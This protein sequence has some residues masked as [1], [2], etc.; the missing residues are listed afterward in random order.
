MSPEPLW[1][2]S[3]VAATQ[4]NIFREHINKKYALN[5]KTYEDLHTWSIDHRSDFWSSLFAYE[6]IISTSK[7]SSPIVDEGATPR[8][9]PPWFSGLQLN[10]AENQLRHA[11][12]DPG[13]ISLIQTAEPC[14]AWTAEPVSV[15]GGKLREMVGSLERAMRKAG[16]GKGDRVAWY[17]GTCVEAVVVLLACTAVGG[18]FSSAAADFGVDGVV[19]RLQ[20]VSS[21]GEV[22]RHLSLDLARALWDTCHSPSLDLDHR[23]A[24]VWSPESLRCEALRQPNAQRRDRRWIPSQVFKLASFHGPSNH[25]NGEHRRQAYLPCLRLSLASR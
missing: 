15:T 13:M 3:D 8:D 23:A 21:V 19:E 22:L 25:S 17:G 16:L 20:Q 24:F 6:N 14:D 2:P 11:I 7:P 12:S 9:N 1:T 10:W 18:I 5:L 4:T